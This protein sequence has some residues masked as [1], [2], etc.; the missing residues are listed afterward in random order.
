MPW[1]AFL[2]TDPVAQV[3]VELVQT[4]LMSGLEPR[5]SVSETESPRAGRAGPRPARR[6]EFPERAAPAQGL[7]DVLLFNPPYVPTPPEEMTVRPT[8]RKGG[9]GRAGEG[10]RGKGRERGRAGARR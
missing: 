7:I 6:A 5:L 1:P 8:G 3:D 9:D 10:G 4:D 2:L